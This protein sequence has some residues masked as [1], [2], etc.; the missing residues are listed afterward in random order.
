[1]RGPGSMEL[2][3]RPD[4]ARIEDYVPIEPLEVLSER[5]GIPI[6]RLVKLDGNENPYGCSPA[7]P[8]APAAHP[9]HKIFPDPSPPPEL[10]RC[11][12]DWLGVGIEPIFAGSG[13]DELL[14]LI[15][16]L[17]ILP[18]DKIINCVPTFGMYSFLTE[19]AGGVV[20]EV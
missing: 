6:E 20:T 19:V 11:L 9:R 12:A 17:F 7:A 18:G 16:R 10:R 15:V 5:L 8:G 1:M 3:I 14:D 4:I 2:P 13:S